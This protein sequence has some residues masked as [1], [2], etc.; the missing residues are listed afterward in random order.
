MGT[1]TPT[2]SPHRGEGVLA[3]P[4][5]HRRLWLRSEATF[6]NFHWANLMQYPCRTLLVMNSFQVVM[7][8]LAVESH[9]TDFQGL[10]GLGDVP[11]MERENPLYML[12]LALS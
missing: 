10:R 7:F 12:F 3:L 6:F 8:N 1:L 9:P 5:C 11:A 4:G 2:L